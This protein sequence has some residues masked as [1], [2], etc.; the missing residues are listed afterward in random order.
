MYR[1][2]SRLY[3]LLISMIRIKQVPAFAGMTRELLCSYLSFI[4]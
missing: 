3:F 2:G 1:I 4:L